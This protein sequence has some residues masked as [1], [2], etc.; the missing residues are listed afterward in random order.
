M[1]VAR[2]VWRPASFSHIVPARQF[3]HETAARLIAA[4]PAGLYSLSP[5]GELLIDFRGCLEC[6]AC[7]LLCD[8]E[9]LLQWRYPA[10]GAGIAYRFG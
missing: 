9:M 2:N 6:G 10:S 3:D 7:R 8:D 5:E 1:S 4:C